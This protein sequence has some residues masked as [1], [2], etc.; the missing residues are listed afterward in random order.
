M[1]EK[2]FT[3][4]DMAMSQGGWTFLLYVGTGR[5]VLLLLPQSRFPEWKP[6]KGEN[7]PIVVLAAEDFWSRP[8]G[9]GV[10][11]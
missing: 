4:A 7:C 8:E 3:K 11:R 10:F 2:R 9:P 5:P 6:L 1:K